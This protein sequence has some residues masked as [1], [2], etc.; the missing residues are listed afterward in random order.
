[1]TLKHCSIHFQQTAAGLE[2]EA[3]WYQKHFSNE[4]I[5]KSV[6]L[7][8]TLTLLPFLLLLLLLMFIVQLA[9]FCVTTS[10]GWWES[11]R[12][13]TSRVARWAQQKSAK[14]DTFIWQQIFMSFYQ[15]TVDFLPSD[16]K[17]DRDTTY[18][19]SPQEKFSSSA[20]IGSSWILTDCFLTI[21]L[22]KA[23]SVQCKING[24]ATWS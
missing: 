16:V 23:Q 7:I 4:M 20:R 9:K 5:V 17:K 3:R 11:A 2:V 13:W 24:H 14:A 22:F 10:A 18:I 6:M 8:H 21:F 19:A 1:M 15:L 12:R